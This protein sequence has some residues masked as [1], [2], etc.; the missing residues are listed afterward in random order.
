MTL[1]CF[2]SGFSQSVN[3]EPSAPFSIFSKPTTSTH[4]TSPPSTACLPSMIAVEPVE[5]LLLTLK[6]GIPVSPTS[7]IALW[8]HVLSP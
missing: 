5:Q 2:D 4:S 8:P 3:L 7:Y 6:T 1:K